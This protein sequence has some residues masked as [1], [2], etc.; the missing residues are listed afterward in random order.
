MTTRM[1]PAAAITPNSRNA[2]N[3]EML[4]PANP[5][6]V[7][8]AAGEDLAD[9]PKIVEGGVP[10][11]ELVV[12]RD[13]YHTL[14]LPCLPVQRD[15]HAADCDG[16][17]KTPLALL[18]IENGV[19]VVDRRD[20]HARDIVPL[21]LGGPPPNLNVLGRTTTHG[22]TPGNEPHDPCQPAS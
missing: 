12:W 5:T 7:V 22:R 3:S 1:T 9:L 11:Q 16:A 13:R 19:A 18:L 17:R 15:S 6:A 2:R 8:T 14:T 20:F 10:Y 4:S 21:D